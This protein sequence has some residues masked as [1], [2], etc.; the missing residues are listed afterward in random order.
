MKTLVQVLILGA[1]LTLTAWAGDTVAPGKTATDNSSSMMG[2]SK[3]CPMQA[4]MCPMTQQMQ[5]QPNI[6]PAMKGGQTN[7]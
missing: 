7:K 4:N 2:M 1:G 3:T 6:C 5:S